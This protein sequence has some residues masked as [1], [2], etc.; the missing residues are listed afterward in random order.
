MVN[1]TYKMGVFSNT[2]FKYDWAI[3]EN[4][5][6]K[7]GMQNDD[8]L[9]KAFGLQQEEYSDPNEL[10]YIQ[11]WFK[12]IDDPINDNK[13][14]V[15]PSAIPLVCILGKKTGDIIEFTLGNDPNSGEELFVRVECDQTIVPGFNPNKWFDEDPAGCYDPFVAEYT[16][17]IYQRLERP[18][19]IDYKK[20]EQE[21]F[22]RDR[23]VS[24][25][26]QKMFN[27]VTK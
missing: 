11:V 13:G 15:F 6:L 18:Y 22:E 20:V 23:K 7:D 21:H 27:G 10:W 12:R 2:L 16:R 19:K 5:L 17:A 26:F 3:R 14:H 24:E 25:N 1:V 8:E 4:E 9:V